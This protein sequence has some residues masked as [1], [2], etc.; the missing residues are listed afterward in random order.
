MGELAVQFIAVCDEGE[1][2]SMQIML[3]STILRQSCTQPRSKRMNENPPVRF[4]EPCRWFYFV[5]G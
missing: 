1:S 5:S 2:L 3:P 4:T